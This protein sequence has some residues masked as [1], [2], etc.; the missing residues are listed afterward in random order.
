MAVLAPLSL[1]FPMTIVA[2]FSKKIKRYL[3]VLC[4]GGS[5]EVIASPTPNIPVGG[6]GYMLK[7]RSEMLG[8]SGYVY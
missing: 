7:S 8:Y 5:W 1:G 4:L 2:K 6:H 3:D